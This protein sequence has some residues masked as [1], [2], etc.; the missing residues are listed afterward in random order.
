MAVTR[1]G[2]GV[3]VSAVVLSVAGIAADY[4]ELILLALAGMVALALA[5]GWL[6]VTRTELAAS[7]AYA[8]QRPYV[9]QTVTVAVTVRNLRRRRSG[10]AATLVDHIDGTPY[11]V[12]VPAI[13]G[14]GDH[15]ARYAFVAPR[16]GHL[17]VSH[18]SVGRSDPLL[19]LAATRL[20]GPAEVIRVLPRW[21]PGAVPLA[22]GGP[23]DEEGLTTASSPHG[24]V[25]F[26]S[27]RDYQPGDQWRLIHWRATAKRG[28]PTVRDQVIPDEPHH[29]ILLDTA[30]A[31]YPPDRFEDAVRIVASLAVA[32]RHVGANLE[33]R[34]TRGGR[35]V[36]LARAAAADHDAALDLLCDVEQ[37]PEGPDLAT[38]LSTLTSRGETLALA[39]VTGPVSDRDAAA[40]SSVRHRFQTAYLIQVAAGRPASGVDGVLHT[41]VATSE[42]FVTAWNRLLRP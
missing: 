42:E 29:L 22:S 28:V 35:T 4:P 34:T 25:A 26:H 14:Q 23:R 39:V 3:L 30:T 1:T 15:T 21:H 11:E 2:V 31:A 12:A 7:R 40:L 33:L 41:S 8:P 5:A 20:A 17:P 19:L 36:R 38:V 6:L 10:P 16:R 24:G 37:S 27:L 9:G 18:L 32:S 13:P